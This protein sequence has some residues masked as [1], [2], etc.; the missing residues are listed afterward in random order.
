MRTGDAHRA[1]YLKRL[2]GIE[3]QSPGRYDLVL[4]ADELAVEDAARLSLSAAEST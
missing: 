1:D 3:R 2:H 4:H